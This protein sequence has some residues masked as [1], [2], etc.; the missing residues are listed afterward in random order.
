MT[1]I[2][3]DT[4]EFRGATLIAKP[5]GSPSDTLVAMKPIVEGIGLDWSAQHKKLTEHPVL[6]S[7]IQHI[8]TVADDGRMREM[9]CLP[10]V[11][12]NYWLATIN[13]NKVPPGAIRERVIEYQ[14]ECADVL[15][16]HFFGRETHKV[17]APPAP[18]GPKPFDEWTLEEIR[19]QLAVANGY[20]HT[21]N[22]AAA[23][24]YMM[25]A[26]FPRPPE[27]LMPAFWQPD[28]DLRSSRS[29]GRSV[30]IIVPQGKEPN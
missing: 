6:S 15:F 13:S 30:T 10:L 17:L 21:L 7:T 22:N 26:G 25:R 29:E 2:N 1:S 11:R 18:P 19:T 28:L 12:L 5:G 16:Q 27:R 20:R 3:I 4:V 24:W 9:V 8:T 23:G 14:T